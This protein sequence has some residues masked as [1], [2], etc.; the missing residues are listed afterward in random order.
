MLTHFFVVV[1][2]E[3]HDN[4]LRNTRFFQKSNCGMPQG[5]EREAP[6]PPDSALFLV[7]N[8]AV[9]LLLSQPRLRQQIGELIGE[10]ARF[11]LLLKD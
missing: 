2:D 9:R 8:F 7:T 5:V 4:C 6:T 3:F 11:P 1:T 10:M